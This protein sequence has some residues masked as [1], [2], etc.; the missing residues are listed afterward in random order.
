MAAHSGAAALTFYLRGELQFRWMFD[1]T[2]TNGIASIFCLSNRTRKVALAANSN[3]LKHHSCFV[4][5][6]DI[7]HRAN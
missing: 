2:T 5:E 6:L 7:S 1:H 3:K 4:D